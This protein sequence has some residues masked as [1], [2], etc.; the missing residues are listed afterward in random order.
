[1]TQKP[2]LS[3]TRQPTKTLVKPPRTTL[4]PLKATREKVTK[5]TKLRAPI[6]PRVKPKAQQQIAKNQRAP[7]APQITTTMM[8]T[9][10]KIMVKLESKPISERVS[11]NA[12]FPS[13]C[14]TCC[15]RSKTEK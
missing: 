4:R 6:K 5:L 9:R 13:G 11:M 7:K 8:M 10:N 3:L 2:M 15:E 14:A 12:L 1:M